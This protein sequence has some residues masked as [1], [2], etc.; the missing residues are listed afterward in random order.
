MDLN[1]KVEHS[2]STRSGVGNVDNV[3]HSF[4]SVPCFTPAV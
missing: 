1:A 4:E 3:L 2:G